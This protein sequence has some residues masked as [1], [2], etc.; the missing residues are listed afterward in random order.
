MYVVMG[1]FGSDPLTWVGARWVARCFRRSP[2][3][4][5]CPKGEGAMLLGG[6]GGEGKGAEE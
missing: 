6:I 2:F 5:L 1:F 4:M 3:L